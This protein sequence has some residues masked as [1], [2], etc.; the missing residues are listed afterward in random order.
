MLPKVSGRPLA[1]QQPFAK[2]LQITEDSSVP[3]GRVHLHGEGRCWRR[4]CGSS[5]GRG[6]CEDNAPA[7]GGASRVAAQ[8]AEQQ[9]FR[10][11]HSDQVV[12]GSSGNS[13][14]RRISPACFSLA[15]LTQ[16]L[17]PPTLTAV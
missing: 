16:A 6:P 7:S 14:R 8:I 12:V 5:F 9:P 4:W 2:G 15:L 13:R 17:L 1:V 3:E 11:F 10:S